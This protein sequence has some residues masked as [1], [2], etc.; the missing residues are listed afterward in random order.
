M[1]PSERRDLLDR[2]RR[3]HASGRVSLRDVARELGGGLS[4]DA[5]KRASASQGWCVERIADAPAPGLDLDAADTPEALARQVREAIRATLADPKRAKISDLVSAAEYLDQ[6]ATAERARAGPDL[7]ALDVHDLDALDRLARKARGEEPEPD[8]PHSP[9]QRALARATELEGERPADA[10]AAA[11]ERAQAAEGRADVLLVE[12]DALAALVAE[13][14][15]ADDRIAGMVAVA[16]A[17]ALDTG[18]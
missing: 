17:P 3:L 8:Y 10:L 5:I 9:L 12:R 15:A 11:H 13:Y 4:Y 18:E 2:A 6:R 1:T 16:M 14:R 7:D